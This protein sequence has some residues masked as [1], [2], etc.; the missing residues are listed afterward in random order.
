MKDNEYI[1]LLEKSNNELVQIIKTQFEL[2]GKVTRQT[3]EA[4]DKIR[5]NVIVFQQ[6]KDDNS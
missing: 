3:K 5:E 2:L 4:L 6:Q 1:T